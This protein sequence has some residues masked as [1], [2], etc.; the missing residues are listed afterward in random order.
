[1]NFAEIAPYIQDPLVLAGFVIFLFFGFCRLLVKKN[2]IPPLTKNLGYRLLQTILLY[3]F[4]IGLVILGLGFGL[5]Y[6][7]M[8]EAEQDRAVALIRSEL[9][10]NS[11]VV[12]QLA[13][14][15][16]TLINIFDIVA[17]SLRKEEVPVLFMLFPESNLRKDLKDPTPH[18]LARLA[19]QKLADSGL[20]ENELE[21]QRAT[22]VGIAIMATISRTEHTIDSLSDSDRARY[23]FREEAFQSHLDILR[24]IDI[25]DLSEL[26]IMYGNMERL[27]DNYDVVVGHIR[28]Y[29]ES[30]HVFFS[31]EDNQI[32][33]TTLTAVLASERLAISILMT[34]TE[35]LV[36]AGEAINQYSKKLG[37][38]ATIS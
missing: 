3:G 5:K 16:E 27:R 2:I 19:I 12:S 30:V 22:A 35:E 33:V 14:N 37:N 20:H 29:L 31:P 8:S 11:Q 1:M 23:T 21:T 32:N 34:F 6:R 25:V 7:E 9:K 28:S 24:K 36:N 15:A 13:A 17:S 10:T 26:E 18:E 4:L 38:Q